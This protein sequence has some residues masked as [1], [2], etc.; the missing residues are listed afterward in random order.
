MYGDVRRAGGKFFPSGREGAGREGPVISGT[1]L[2][3]I[4][5]RDKRYYGGSDHAL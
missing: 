3:Y 4:W 2:P 1:D 5:N